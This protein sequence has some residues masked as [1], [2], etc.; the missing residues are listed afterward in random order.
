M[1][2]VNLAR[3]NLHSY[4][5]ADAP[6][7]DQQ[8]EHQVFVEETHLILDRI[9]IHSLEEHMPGAVSSFARAANGRLAIVA[10]MAAETPLVN[11]PIG[12]AVEGQAAMLQFV[13]GIDGITGKDLRRRLVHQI[14]AALDGII[15]MPFPVIFLQVAQGRSHTA[16]SRAGV[17]ARGVDL[18]QHRYAGLGQLHCGHQASAAR[19]NDY[20]V[21]FIV[22]RFPSVLSRNAETGRADRGWL[23]RG[24]SRW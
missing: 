1:E 22:H 8:I 15:H 11:A 20:H 17:R 19:A 18:T 6:L 3:A 24:T 9:L 7:V 2:R 23:L 16:L 21:E 10:G 12:R 14:V 4:H 13:N 5:A